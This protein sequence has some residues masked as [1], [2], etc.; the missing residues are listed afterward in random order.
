M[1]ARKMW[2]YVIDIKKK[3]VQKREVHIDEQLRNGNIRLSKP[4]QI[5]LVFL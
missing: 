2:D 4:P 1:L 5:V 3:F